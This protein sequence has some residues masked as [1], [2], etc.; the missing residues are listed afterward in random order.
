MTNS[1]FAGFS[2]VDSKDA[3]PK[4]ADAADSAAAA[5][6]RAD[7][8]PW[9]TALG[10][11]LRR[12][13]FWLLA[14][15]LAT[16]VAVFVFASS[17]GGENR[18]PLAVDNAAPAGAM[19][20]ATV[21]GRHGITVR[22]T[23]SLKATL[24]A[25]RD[26]PDSTVL[27][28]DRGNLLRPEGVAQL[29]GAAQSVVAVAP[30]PLALKALTRDITVAGS[31]A[32]GSGTLDAACSQPD[33][34]AAGRIGAASNDTFGLTLYRGPVVCFPDPAAST[35]VAPGP[36]GL[37]ATT[38]DGSLTVLGAP[39]IFSNQFAAEAGN[40]ALV[41][42]TLGAHR[43][44]IWYTPSLADVP[45]SNG[46]AP[47]S[48]LTP[49]WVL[50]A[51]L[52]LL[53]VGVAAMLWRGRRDGP[54]VAEPLPV[55]VKSSEA[56]AGRARLYQQSGAVETAAGKLLSGTLVRLARHL[57]LDP[58]AGSAGVAAAAAAHSTWTPARVQETLSTR[59]RTE[60]ALLAWAAEL[61]ALEKEVTGP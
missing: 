30:G 15:A 24:E 5:T 12:H 18:Q 26:H 60:K 4:V 59:P 7:A 36:A 52:W 47:L 41:L 43:T 20:V 25:L 34:A 2:G 45:T 27:L 35:A 57:R 28:Y 44:L 40:A 32:A 13:R 1:P 17:S 19:A 42:R 53:L 9:T 16:A 54:L 22:P 56:V 21:L 14:G 10:G 37:M 51:G 31:P 8:L 6:F 48:A 23:D 39:G 46:P 55:I 50:P 11:W 49:P 3:G 29:A 38:A 58:G 33:A 61:D